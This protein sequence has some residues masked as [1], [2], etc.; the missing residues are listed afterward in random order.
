MR[1]RCIDAVITELR[2]VGV[3]DFKIASG[4]KHPQVHWEVNGAPRFYAVPGT[5]GDVRSALNARADI[6]R[7]LKADGLIAAP[8]P[9]ERQSPRRVTLVERVERLERLVERLA[10]GAMRADQ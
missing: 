10:A 9:A 3:Y 2:A 6:R 1:N 4:G 7:M 5:P 8:E